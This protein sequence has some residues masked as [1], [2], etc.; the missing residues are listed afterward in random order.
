MSVATIGIDV[1]KTWFHLIGFDARGTAVARERFNRGQLLRYMSKIAPAL[2]GMDAS[3]GSHHL[4]RGLIALGHDA[5]LM[6]AKFVRPFLKGN[7]NDYLDAEAIAE[8]VQRPTMRFV[9]LKT[10][11]QLDL[12]AIHRIRCGLIS[13]R[14]GVINQIRSFLQDRGI[15]IATGP[16]VLARKLLELLGD[17]EGRLTV[18]MKRLLTML[19]EQ[20]SAMRRWRNSKPN[21]E[22]LS[23]KMTRA[24]AWHRSWGLA[25]SPRR[26]SWLQSVTGACSDRD[27]TLRPGS[28][29]FLVS[30]RLADAQHCLGSASEETP[31]FGPC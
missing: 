16:S 19:R 3:C 9:P 2:V 1:G 11:E 15:T 14:T 5:R 26:Q 24:G 17:D 8:A 7:K 27:V 31:T 10:I 30:T 21:S 12:Q 29:S 20:C 6:S 18:G 4:A 28:A 22:R 25:R 13:R 23:S